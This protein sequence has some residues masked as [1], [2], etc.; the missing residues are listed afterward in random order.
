M[1]AVSKKTVRGWIRTGHLPAFRY[2]K[3]LIRI[4][5]EAAEALGRPIPTTAVRT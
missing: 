5:R 1:Y 3:R 2:G 4:D